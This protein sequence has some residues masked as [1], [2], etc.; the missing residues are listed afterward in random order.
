MRRSLVRPSGF[1]ARLWHEVDWVIVFLT[2][3]I[4][5]LGLINLRSAGG[6]QWHGYVRD[7]ANWVVIGSVIMGGLAMIDYRVF[8]RVAYIV[9]G[10]GVGLVIMVSVQGVM[11]NSAQ[12]WL[13]LGLFRFQPSELMKLLLVIGLARY[14]QDGTEGKRRLL[15]GVFYPLLM[16]GVPA[17]LVIRQPALSTGIMLTVIGISIFAATRLT[18]KGTLGLLTLGVLGFM[19]A[20]QSALKNYQRQRIDVWL[21]PETYPEQG[22]YQILQA[23]TAV[24]NGGLFGRG[25]GQGTQNILDFVPYGESDF[26]FAVFAEEWGFVGTT[27]LLALYLCLV[28]WAINL[29]SQ[30]RDR[31]GAVLS[32]GVAAMFFWHVVFN[33]GVVLEL[34]PNT[35]LPLP[36]F[37]HGGS[38]V[39][40]M[41]SALGILMSVSRFRDARR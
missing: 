27:T 10:A 15:P 12:R 16:V 11:I 30:A 6:G 17:L 20:W 35:G 33:V 38:N 26:A 4:V 13:D 40:T 37:T 18:L 36:F 25:V 3:C 9:Y 14:L 24:G 32:I 21:S 5:T 41:M 8:H 34:F 19:V 28:L 23:R 31:M 39:I 1:W 22:G 7:Q 2:V 29:A